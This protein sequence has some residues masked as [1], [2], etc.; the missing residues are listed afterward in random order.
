LLI[1]PERKAEVE[2][3][4]LQGRVCGVSVESAAA[5]ASSRISGDPGTVSRP[6][7]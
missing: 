3:R 4:S 1:G 7:A 5:T 6:K 2:R